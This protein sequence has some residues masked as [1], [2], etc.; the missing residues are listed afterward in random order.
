[1]DFDF[2]V[3]GGGSAGYAAASTAARAGLT[4]A[5]IDGSTRLGGL[6]IL[7]GCMPSKAL[8]E[9][10]NRRL[11]LRHAP[12]FGLHPQ[13]HAAD[14][15]A[16]IRRKNRHISEFAAYRASQ[17]ESG[18]HHLIRG[19][20]SFAEGHTLA[21]TAADGS[22]T[23]VTAR[24]F[25]IATGSRVFIPD[26]EGLSEAGFWTSNDILE[27]EALPESLIVL[28]GGAIA[29]E[30]AHYAEAMGCRTTV[31]Q[32]SPHLLSAFDPAVGDTLQRAL[33]ARMDIHTGTKLLKVDS[34]SGGKTLT[35]L[36]ETKTVRSIAASQILV[37]LGRQPE[38]GT[39]GLE[40]AGVASRNGLITCNDRRQTSAPHI[41]AAGDCSDNHQVVHTAIQHAEI[42]AR[43][44][45][46]L[47]KGEGSPWES[48][49]RRLELTGIFTE[50]QAAVLG[51]GEQQA[52]ASGRK[53]RCS[54]HPFNDHGK[55]ILM[56]VTEGFVKLV[57]DAE[58]GEILGASVVGPHATEL[59]HEIVVAMHFRA[60]TAQLASIPHYHPTL[61]EIWT[62]PAE[63]LS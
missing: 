12:A 32:R 46:R 28:G 42:A 49:D 8:I 13:S 37:A 48:I 35:F 60:T 19:T 25:C 29:L 57:A 17:L 2:A 61:S 55:S 36:D 58:S 18:P 14:L 6:C 54:S 56:E 11:D 63:S 7:K 3:I 41:F 20:A 31:I 59:I 23:T 51:L 33:S 27:A 4:T 24:S 50:P 5:V 21:V 39:L 44:A 15:P 16:I 10:A 62:Y 38:T 26:L 34:S 43:N 1:M 9:S 30:M 53:V 22:V 40:N 52:A 47:L 45:L